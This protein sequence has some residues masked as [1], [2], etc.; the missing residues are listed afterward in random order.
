MYKEE[1]DKILGPDA[2]TIVMDTNNDK[3]D[4]FKSIVVIVM[5]KQKC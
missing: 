5:R 2:T 3:E 1:L 4:R